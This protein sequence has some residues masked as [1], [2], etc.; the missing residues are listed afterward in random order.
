M[1]VLAIDPARVS[2][3]A[4]ACDE[5]IIASGVAEEAHERRAVVARAASMA[6]PERPLVVVYE[7]SQR[8]KLSP[9]TWL[10][11]GDARGRWLE[12]VELEARLRRCDSVGVE[13]SVWRTLLWGA[14]RFHRD[15]WKAIAVTYARSLGIEPR[16]DDEAEAIA[17]AMVAHRLPDVQSQRASALR[18]AKR[19]KR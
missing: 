8:G 16:T 11:M 6:T 3:W 12:H 4:I 15:Y 18:R 7:R 17:I 5:Q 19:A 14:K 1:I 9:T 13:P 10:G 2:G